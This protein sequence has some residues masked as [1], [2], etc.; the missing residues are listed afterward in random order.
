MQR[1][2]MRLLH[3]KALTTGSENI[4]QVRQMHMKGVSAGVQ[5]CRCLISDAQ[6]FSPHF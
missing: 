1:R 6:I 2:A 5:V 4:K 3:L